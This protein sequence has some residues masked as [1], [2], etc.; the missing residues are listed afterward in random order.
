MGTERTNIHALLFLS[1]A[2]IRARTAKRKR[3]RR[4]LLASVAILIPFA[5]LPT[6]SVFKRLGGYI[7]LSSPILLFLIH[8]F[9]IYIVLLQYV[10]RIIRS[11]I[12]YTLAHFNSTTKNERAGGRTGG[13][14][15]FVRTKDERCNW[16]ICRRM[17]P[18][19]MLIVLTLSGENRQAG[20][21]AGRQT[22]GWVTSEHFQARLAFQ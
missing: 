11:L 14:L 19:M 2:C 4:G 9:H 7:S 15:A 21:Q 18:L 13:C 20:R 5:L 8:E 1:L 6:S 22:E 10:A 12:A 16:E 17:I 3:K